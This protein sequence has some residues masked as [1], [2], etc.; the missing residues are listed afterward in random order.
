MTASQ[1]HWRST[2]PIVTPTADLNP[3]EKPTPIRVT[4]Y[5]GTP[6]IELGNHLLASIA[7]IEVISVSVRRS[8]VCPGIKSVMATCK[9]ST[10]NQRSYGRYERFP[11]LVTR[12]LNF[13]QSMAG[14]DL[15][16]S[17]RSNSVPPVLL[18]QQKS[19]FQRTLLDHGVLLLSLLERWWVTRRMNNHCSSSDEWF[20][21][22]SG[23]IIAYTGQILDT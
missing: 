10:Q 7:Y 4:Q 3:K 22:E 19:G 17:A 13:A 8:S 11:C 14:I 5:W 20:E 15:P 21:R 16:M 2:N 6:I 23:H 12:R 1:R 18:V 9:N